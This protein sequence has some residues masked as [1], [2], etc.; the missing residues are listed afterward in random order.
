MSTTPTRVLPE[1][2][3]VR[4]LTPNDVG[5]LRG[6]TPGTYETDLGEIARDSYPSFWGWPDRYNEVVRKKSRLEWKARARLF[7][8]EK[9]QGIPVTVTLWYRES[10]PGHAAEHR[11]GLGPINRVRAAVPP[12]FDTSSLMVVERAPQSS[13]YDF[14]VRLITANDP[15]YADFAAY[16]TEERPE[17]RHGYGR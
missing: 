9:P 3:F 12:S 10:R 4:T 8:S 6:N 7:S 13:D 15:D 14:I 16:L 1:R 2:F 17:H 11:M 5:K